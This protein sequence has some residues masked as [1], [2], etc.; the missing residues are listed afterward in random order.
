MW[1]T[2]PVPTS[3]C[4]R[5][6]TASHQPV[7]PIST[8]SSTP[9]ASD[10]ALRP[11]WGEPGAQCGQVAFWSGRAGGPVDREAG[12][13][14][15]AGGPGALEA[16]RGAA[17]RRDG[18]VVAGVGDR[19][20]L[21]ALGGG[22]VPGVG[23]LLIAGEGELERPAADRRSAALIAVNAVHVKLFG[24]VEYGFSSLKIVA[25]LAFILLG[26]WVVFRQVGFGNYTS[27]GGFLPHGAWGMW[28][29]VLV[30]IFSYFSIEMIAVAAGEARD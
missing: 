5:A 8:G 4:T 1:A 10:G 30:S 18:G 3:A 6:A 26:A 13:D 12:R 7:S 21:P 16:H 9:A 14:G 24:A 27:H 23:D 11:G 25:I 2:S 15:V 17:A 29:A 22:A 19:H 28:I 20:G